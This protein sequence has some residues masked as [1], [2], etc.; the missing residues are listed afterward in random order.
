MKHLQMPQVQEIVKC[1]YPCTFTENEIIIREG[2]YGNRLYVTAGEN[3]HIKIFFAKIVHHT[4][5]TIK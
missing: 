3:F 2:E 4:F 1:M 5:F